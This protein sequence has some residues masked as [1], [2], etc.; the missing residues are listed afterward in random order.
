MNMPKLNYDFEAAKQMLRDKT[1]R[2]SAIV[3]AANLLPDQ[4]K[5]FWSLIA[6]RS[7]ISY[8]IETSR[9]RIA[10]E[11]LLQADAGDIPWQAKEFLKFEPSYV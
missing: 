11:E 7:L 1:E 6:A 8:E 5:E 9:G 2:L 3:D 4:R 10:M